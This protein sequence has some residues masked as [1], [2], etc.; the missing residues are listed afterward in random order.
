MLLVLLTLVIGGWFLTRTGLMDIDTIDVQGATHETPD[1]VVA[2]SGLRLGDQLLDI[3]E[4]AVA[5]SVEQLPWVATAEVAKGLD[6]VVS[7]TIT[8]R[9]PEATVA[10]AAGGRH[11]VDASGRLLGPDEGAIGGLVSLELVTAA[12]PGQTIE[13]ADGAM[14][15]IA[16]LGA[17][18]ESRITR[19]KVEPDGTIT[20]ALNPQ[21]VVLLGPPTDLQAKAVALATMLG[22]VEQG[23]L[24]SISV[25]DPDNPILVRTPG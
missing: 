3:D 9:V 25:V 2:A 20:L 19:V 23:H 12:E 22:Q 18:T 7:I 14:A 21:G 1:E 16:A 13:G 15:A 8:E 24:Q 6:G 4:G 11:L 17:G 10:D 5:R